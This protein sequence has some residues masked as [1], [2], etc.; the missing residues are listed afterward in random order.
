MASAGV[1]NG[2]QLFLLYSS[3][4]LCYL[5]MTMDNNPD[6]IREIFMKTGA[7]LEGHFLLT[8][9]RHSAT[10]WEKFRIL[11]YPNYTATLCR[12]ITSHF[13]TEHIEVVVGPTT[14][15]II[16]AY[17]VARQLG[18][19]GI[20][21]EKAEEGRVLR[22]GFDI[23]PGERV[24]IVDDVLTTGKSLR[25]VMGLVN[26]YG[27]NLIGI[28]IMVDRSEEPAFYNVPLI[29]CLRARDVSYTPEACPLCARG[30]PLMKP[31]GS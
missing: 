31:G 28:G 6:E 29:S 25:E 18:T 9:G 26:A 19:R 16:L 7:L 3:N 21:A 24:L 27:G 12:R 4:R 20:F 15:G 13:A 2:P 10:Y 14:G 30:I 8:S 23:K 11:Q 17:E 22:R 5:L 1:G